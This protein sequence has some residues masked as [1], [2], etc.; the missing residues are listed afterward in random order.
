MGRISI[1]IATFI[2]RVD[3]YRDTCAK[4]SLLERSIYS[5]QTRGHE[6]AKPKL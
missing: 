4:E 3:I 2:E 5:V 1:Y 6:N